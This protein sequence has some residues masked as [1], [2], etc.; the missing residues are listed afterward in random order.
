V[1]QPAPGECPEEGPKTHSAD[2]RNYPFDW[3]RLP[4]LCSCAV[5]GYVTECMRKK[6]IGLA[7]ITVIACLQFVACDDHRPSPEVNAFATGNEANDLMLSLPQDKQLSALGRFVS[8]AGYRCVGE[9]VFYAGIAQE[10]IAYWSVGCTDG[11]SYQVEFAHD[12]GGSTKILDCQILKS[13]AK[14]DCFVK[15]QD[16]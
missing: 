7:A 10:R 6:N 5:A 14:S 4:P 3:D 15:L 11:H 12:A 13:V 1:A 9:R 2:D 16:R 8:S